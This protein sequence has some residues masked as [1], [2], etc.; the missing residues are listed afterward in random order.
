MKRMGPGVGSS[1]SNEEFRLRSELPED[2]RDAF[3]TVNGE[4]GP[5]ATEKDQVGKRSRVIH[6]DQTRETLIKRRPVPGLQHTGPDLY[7]LGS[8]RY[9]KRQLS[10]PDPG[11]P[12]PDL[13]E[14]PEGVDKHHVDLLR[15]MEQLGVDEQVIARLLAD[16]KFKELRADLGNVVRIRRSRNAPDKVLLDMGVYTVTLA[17]ILVRMKQHGPACKLAA[18]CTATERMNVLHELFFGGIEHIVLAT[19]ELA[20]LHTSV[21]REARWSLRDPLRF[22]EL[23]DWVSRNLKKVILADVISN[24]AN[25]TLVLPLA[26]EMPPELFVEALSLAADMARQAP[27]E[28]SVT[29]RLESL[30][31]ACS[32]LSLSHFAP[33]F[34]YALRT[35]CRKLEQDDESGFSASSTACVMKKAYSKADATE[36]RFGSELQTFSDHVNFAAL[37]LL[38]YGY[39]DEFDRLFSRRPDDNSKILVLAY[40]MRRGQLVP[41]EAIGKMPPNIVI[42]SMQLAVNEAAW[43]SNDPLSE[44]AD[45]TRSCSKFLSTRY[46]ATL[47]HQLGHACLELQKQGKI[48]EEDVQALPAL[49]NREDDFNDNPLFPDQVNED[50]F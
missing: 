27:N 8:I 49:A 36:W 48:S 42:E 34:I 50:D 24:P 35:A 41:K 17:S 21:R 22:K 43:A 9:D 30:A 7:D 19:D 39:L 25:G 18:K 46:E 12:Q 4:Y 45:L 47:A 29:V 26:N 31:K 11:I 15:V 16:R 32:S 6:V 28:L 5:I 2:T 10:N 13:F 33:E 23:F 1:S 38:H 37:R 20:A 3:S 40:L 44:L 14:L